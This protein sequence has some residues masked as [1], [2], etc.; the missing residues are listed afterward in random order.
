[1]EILLWMYLLYSSDF[2]KHVLELCF[3]NSRI[4]CFLKKSVGLDIN[5]RFTK[6]I[7]QTIFPVTNISSLKEENRKTTFEHNIYRTVNNWWT[8]IN[9]AG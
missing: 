7:N 5:H 1:M 8:L 4:P 6:Q 9:D 2:W 3:A